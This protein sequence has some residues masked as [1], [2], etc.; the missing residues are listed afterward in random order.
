MIRPL[1]FTKVC[2][3]LVLKLD[4]LRFSSITAFR[5]QRRIS[6]MG[7]FMNQEYGGRVYAKCLCLCVIIY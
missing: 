1:N 7:A 5:G 2:I 6:C 4:S 3:H